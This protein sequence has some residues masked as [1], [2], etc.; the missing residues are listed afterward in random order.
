MSQSETSGTFEHL[1]RIHL[2]NWSTTS[3]PLVQV[4][5]NRRDDIDD[6]AH[7]ADCAFDVGDD[8]EKRASRKQCAARRQREADADRDV[9]ALIERG[10]TRAALCR[11][12]ARHGAAVYR[13]CRKALR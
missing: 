9:I 5:M 7:S 2:A 4:A 8:G 1:S 12:M 3:R 11:V 10:E 6:P 13:Y